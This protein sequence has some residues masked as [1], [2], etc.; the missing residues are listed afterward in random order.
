MHHFDI[1]INIKP[2]FYSCIS[3]A[4]VSH[5]QT[6]LLQLA[7]FLNTNIRPG[8]SDN[9]NYVDMALDE[10]YTKYM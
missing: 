5:Q 4:A 8:P 10:L 6:F 3:L 7:M 2:E 9:S 1:H